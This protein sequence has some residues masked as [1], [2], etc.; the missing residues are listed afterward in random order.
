M[1]LIRKDIQRKKVGEQT[2]NHDKCEVRVSVFDCKFS[3]FL[4]SCYFH[5]RDP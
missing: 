5:E 2:D 4:R 1:D 3:L